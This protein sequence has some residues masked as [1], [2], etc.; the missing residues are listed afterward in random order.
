VPLCGNAGAAHA[1]GFAAA[2]GTRAGARLTPRA[3]CFSSRCLNRRS[4]PA[5]RS[6]LALVWSRVP[7]RCQRQSGQMS[8]DRPAWMSAAEHDAAACRSA[9]SRRTPERLRRACWEALSFDRRS[10]RGSS[11]G[12]RLMGA[13]RS[14]H[15]QV[16]A[17]RASQAA[18]ADGRIRSEIAQPTAL[19]SALTLQLSLNTARARERGRLA[20]G[21]RPS[22]Y[23]G[24]VTRRAARARCS[25]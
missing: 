3:N 2:L 7:L 16:V 6:G 17:L 25:A 24:P 22:F 11:H 15:T 4:T 23:L 14:G 10:T 20:A 1:S 18:S 13:D 12:G 9:L 19:L 8:V 5:L 21:N